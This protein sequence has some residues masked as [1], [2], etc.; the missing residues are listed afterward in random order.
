M[1]VITVGIS[2]CRLSRDP[3]TVLLTHALGSCIGVA[4]HDPVS[5]VAGLLHFLL[6][7]SRLNPAKARENPF[8]YA[9]TGIPELFHRAYA[10]GAEKGRLRVAVVGGAQVMDCGVFNIGTHNQLACRKILWSAGLTIQGEETG[11]DVSRTLRLD[12]GSGAIHWNT[13]AGPVHELS[14]RK[15]V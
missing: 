12:V 14:T 1:A 2:D 4:I 7:A 6:P 13:G 10:L 5:H 15:G 8:V 11:G 9:D 3:G